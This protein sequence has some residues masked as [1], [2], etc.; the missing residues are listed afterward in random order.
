MII[1][2]NVNFINTDLLFLRKGHRK[3]D[4]VYPYILNILDELNKNQ[5]L[6]LFSVQEFVKKEEFPRLLVKPLRETGILG[7]PLKRI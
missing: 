5:K 4:E 2:H 1:L 3:M 6:T 7:S